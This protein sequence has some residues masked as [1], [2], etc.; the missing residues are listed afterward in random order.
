MRVHIE[1]R[2]N[3]LVAEPFRHHLLRPAGGEQQRRA[4]VAPIPRPGLINLK[5]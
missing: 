4:G 5:T 2:F 1:R 3:V